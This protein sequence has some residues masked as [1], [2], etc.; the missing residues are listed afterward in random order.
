M[1]YFEFEYKEI[2]NELRYFDIMN[3]NKVVIFHGSIR[4]VQTKQRFDLTWLHQRE[5]KLHLE[6]FHFHVCFHWWTVVRVNNHTPNSVQQT[7]LHFVLLM[8]WIVSFILNL[9]QT[10]IGSVVDF[11]SNFFV[12]RYGDNNPIITVMA[13]IF[14]LYYFLQQHSDMGKIVCKWLWNRW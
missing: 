7:S 1:W 10:D 12:Y 2:P 9:L 5:L 3:N 14:L 11:C 8:V 13:C 6:I 4:F